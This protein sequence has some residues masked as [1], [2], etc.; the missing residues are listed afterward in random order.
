MEESDLV[1]GYL[2]RL[3][4]DWIAYFSAPEDSRANDPNLNDPFGIIHELVKHSPLHAWDFIN[5]VLAHDKGELTL[6][7]L[8]ASPLEDFI[9]FHGREWIETIEEYARNDPRFQALL[10]GVW[11]SGTPDD[12][13]VRI[14]Q[15]QGTASS[16]PSKSGCVDVR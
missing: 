9:A 14:V 2:A 6:D 8:A 4:A 7:L 10:A 16:F 5:Y 12:V 11:Q 3:A 13:W 15:A 1:D